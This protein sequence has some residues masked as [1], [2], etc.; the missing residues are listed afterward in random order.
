MK[1][2]LEGVIRDVAQFLDRQMSDLMINSL[3]KHLHIDNIR[4][5]TAEML[6]GQKG[7]KEMT[8]FFRK[9]RIG[10]WKNYSIENDKKWNR[11]IH[12]NSHGLNV[13]FKFE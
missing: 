2:N 1:T 12:E 10:D 4:K 7:Q 5:I 13:N 11:W 3:V 6:S 9:G 8:Q